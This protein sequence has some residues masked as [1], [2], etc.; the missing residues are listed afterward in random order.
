MDLERLADWLGGLQPALERVANLPAWAAPR[1]VAGQLQIG[2]SQGRP[3]VREHGLVRLPCLSQLTWRDLVQLRGLG[4][5]AITIIWSAERCAACPQGMERLP[6]LGVPL[7]LASDFFP[8]SHSPEPRQ[9]LDRDRRALLFAPLERLRRKEAPDEAAANPEVAPDEAELLRLGFATL[10]PDTPLPL[11][12]RTVGI[13]CTFCGACRQ[14]CPAYQV[15]G[16]TVSWQPDRCHECGV[17]QEI[18]PAGV[19]GH[20]GPVKAGQWGQALVLAQSPERTC[21]CGE[22]YYN[23][24]PA[25]RCLRCE[26]LGDKGD[27]DGPRYF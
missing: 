21:A 22:H 6:E 1:A 26:L 25:K 2:C 20:G 9:G 10:D 11:R 3:P 18:C 19:I 12:Q 8:A 5:T 27:G 16:G 13:G 23:N 17:C 7:T 4:V 24:D 15:A 14:A